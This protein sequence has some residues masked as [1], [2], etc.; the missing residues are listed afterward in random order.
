M[1]IFE[2]LLNL[3]LYCRFGRCSNVFAGCSRRA[4]DPAVTRHFLLLRRFFLH[5]VVLVSSTASACV[6][7]MYFLLSLGHVSV[8]LG[9][10]RAGRFRRLERGTVHLQPSQITAPEAALINNACLR[11]PPNAGAIACGLVEV[12][13]PWSTHELKS[14]HQLSPAKGLWSSCGRAGEGEQAECQ[15]EEMRRGHDVNLYL[16]EIAEAALK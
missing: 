5:S 13:A 11:R 10:D 14:V 3:L 16:Q 1:P 12:K 4:K 2:M 9:T 6:L 15:V 8:T 7:Q